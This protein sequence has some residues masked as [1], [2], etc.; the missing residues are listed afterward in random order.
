VLDLKGENGKQK[1]SALSLALSF[2]LPYQLAARPV[3]VDV[4]GMSRFLAA[5]RRSPPPRRFSWV[6][7]VDYRT[8]R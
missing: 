6:P 4:V 3:F 5:R 8:P 2:S 7:W 1:I